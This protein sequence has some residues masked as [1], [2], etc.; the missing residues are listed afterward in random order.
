MSKKGKEQPVEEL[1]KMLKSLYKKEKIQSQMIKKFQ[2]LICNDGLYSTI[3][4]D[5]PYPMVV[6][7]ENGDLVFVNNALSTETGLD[8]VCKHNMLN[9]ITDENLRILDATENVFLGKTTFL[10]GLSEP[11]ELFMSDG[12]RGK[13]SSS[14]YREAVFFPISEENGQTVLGAVIFIK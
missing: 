12:I 4:N 2:K 8:K 5:F 3:L 13:T 1:M 7:E 10:S 11:L 9:R 14:G 6:F